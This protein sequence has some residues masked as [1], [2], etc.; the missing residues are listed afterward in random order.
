MSD[1][2]LDQDKPKPKQTGIFLDK[3]HHTLSE[4]RLSLYFTN[5]LSDMQYAVVT[6]ILM[7][8]KSYVLND[9]VNKKLQNTKSSSCG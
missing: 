7:A 3:I 9:I 1:A 6:D 5:S 8:L 2:R 4:H